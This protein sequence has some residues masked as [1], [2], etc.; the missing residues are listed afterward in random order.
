VIAI[1]VLVIGIILDGIEFGVTNSLTTCVDGNTG[2]IYG[3]GGSSGN[4]LLC[5]IGDSHDCSCVRDQS[6]DL[7]YEFNLQAADNCG[8]ILN[9]L[10]SLLLA[11]LLFQL[12]L[13]GT[14]FA[15]SICTCRSVCCV[16]EEG[17]AALAAPATNNL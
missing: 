11:S 10:P 14:V 5:A 9:Q 1:I 4:A 3:D 13:F 15:Y 2:E 17:K 16:K 8:Q 12:L 6:G 7:C